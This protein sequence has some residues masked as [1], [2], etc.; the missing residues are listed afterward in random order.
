MERCQSEGTAIVSAQLGVCC[1]AQGHLGIA[2]EVNWHLQL[3]VHTPYFGPCRVIA[4]A[5]LH[6]RDKA[7][8]HLHSCQRLSAFA[9]GLQQFKEYVDFSIQKFILYSSLTVCILSTQVSD[10]S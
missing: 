1:L 2:Q 5:S 10:Y 4:P 8:Y 3:P 7:V 6:Q 9:T